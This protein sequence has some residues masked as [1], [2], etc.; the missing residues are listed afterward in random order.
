M[1]L[2]AVLIIVG[3]VLAVV[4]N[5]TRRPSWLLAAAIVAVGF[6]VLVGFEPL[7]RVP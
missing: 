5:F 1:E 7:V 4:A 6:G 2:G 3:I